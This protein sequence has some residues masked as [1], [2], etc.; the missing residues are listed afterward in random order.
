LQ[1]LAKNMNNHL[2][3]FLN[4]AGSLLCFGYWGV[5]LPPSVQLTLP[6]TLNPKLT[7]V[8]TNFA[9]RIGRV[10]KVI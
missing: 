7:G 6:Q 8:A 3:A 1:P 5:T 10:Y 9:S 4:S 2:E